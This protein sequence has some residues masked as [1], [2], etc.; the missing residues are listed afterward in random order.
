MSNNGGVLLNNGGVVDGVSSQVGVGHWLVDGGNN[1]GNVGNG[2]NETVLV[3]ILGESFQVDWCESAGCCHQVAAEDGG[4][5]STDLGCGHGNGEK[6]REDDL[7][8]NKSKLF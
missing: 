3:E 4:N 1:W 6:G 5:W 8:K 7:K 2:V